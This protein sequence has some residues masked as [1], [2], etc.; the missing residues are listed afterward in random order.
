MPPEDAYD[1]YLYERYESAA[2]AAA[3]HDATGDGSH[4][5]G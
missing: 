5:S 2:D 4:P 3:L 1:N